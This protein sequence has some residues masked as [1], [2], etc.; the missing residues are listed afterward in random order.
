MKGRK[1]NKMSEQ[2]KIDSGLK[3]YNVVD[4]DGRLFCQITFNPS[5]TGIA[6]RYE[7]VKRR[8]FVLRNGSSKKSKKKSIAEQL[9]ELNAIVYEQIDYLLNANVSET[10][11][12]IMGPFSPLPSGQFFFENI[13]ESICQIIR[14]ES[15]INTAKVEEKIS[16]YTKKYHN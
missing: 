7:E 5:D 10:I 8:L 4:E 3:T 16:K 6:K 15:K 12:S 2:I 1:E 9:N 14:E 13:L 11:F